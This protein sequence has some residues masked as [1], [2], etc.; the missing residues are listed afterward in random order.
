MKRHFHSETLLPSKKADGKSSTSREVS[1]V[2]VNN[3]P[4][5]YNLMKVR[6]LFSNCGII[7]HID[8]TESLDKTY[9]L[10][11]IE[12]QRYDEALTALTK[13]LKKIGQNEITVN[14]LENC[15]IWITNF[16]PQYTQRDIKNLFLDHNAVALSVRFPS[17]RYN[18]N[19]RFA[20]VDVSS[21]EEA[22]R[23]TA[24]LNDKEVETY[25]LVVKKSNPIEKSKRSDY[26]AS[27]R[28][29]IIVR[30]LDITKMNEQFL[31]QEFSKFGEVESIT[32]PSK[33]DP[34][35][36]T[37]YAFV[38]FAE[39]SAALD[40]LKVK[41]LNEKEVSVKL[42]DRKAYV[43]RQKVKAIMQGKIK[44]DRI[45]SLFPLKENTSKTQIEEM[46]LGKTNFTHDD[47]EEILL[48]PD[49]GGALIILRDSKQ[50]ARCSMSLN[51]CEFQ[52]TVLRCGAV[53]DLH[54]QQTGNPSRPVTFGSTTN[55]HQK[56]E[57]DA[58]SPQPK[59]SNEDFRKMFL[60]K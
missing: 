4:K 56:S 44:N 54:K 45:I 13:T 10:A 35:S 23:I 49:K 31:Q 48:V 55:S 8:V 47:L 20:Y 34:R 22:D 43:E 53:Y 40:S 60:R 3:L 59:L 1:T 6:K 17:L 50:A 57:Q 37:G 46:L 58:G 24:E 28:R 33:Q 2:L 30:Q 26:G 29:E 39:Q 15:T 19:R 7:N 41:A 32:I 18:S 14:L 11:R 52:K 51:G 16:P 27:E 9:R 5:S 38:T 21:T 42:A 12:F 36:R 25:R